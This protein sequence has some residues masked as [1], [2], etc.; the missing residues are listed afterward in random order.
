MNRTFKNNNIYEILKNNEMKEKEI[1]INTFLKSIEK[2]IIDN[3]NLIEEK[4]K[5][6]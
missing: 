5:A 1:R 2:L 4:K 3:Q 6:S